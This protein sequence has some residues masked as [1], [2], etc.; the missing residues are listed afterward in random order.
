MGVWDCML[1]SQVPSIL[2]LGRE[3]Q[4][5]VGDYSKVKNGAYSVFSSKHDNIAILSTG[6]EVELSIN[7]A[8][9]LKDKHGLSIRVISVPCLEIFEKQ[10]D[11]YKQTLLPYQIKDIFAIEMLSGFEWYKHVKGK[12]IVISNNKFGHSAEWNEEYKK[13]MNF[14][15]QYI[16]EI[17]ESKLC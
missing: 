9:V 1:N 14:D 5:Q 7:I 4:S 13:K 15:M 11:S 6:A 16:I 12:G 3:K 10:D 8:K 17:F 2:F